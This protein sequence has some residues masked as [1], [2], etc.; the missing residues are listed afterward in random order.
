MTL[1]S[2]DLYE[3]DP[4]TAWAEDVVAGKLIAGPHIRNAA[5]RHLGDL[6]KGRDRGLVWMPEKG[7]QKIN[8]IEKYCRLNGGRFEGKPFLLHNSQKFRV[9][10]IFGWYKDDG[11]RRFNYLYDEEGKGNGKSPLLA[12]IGSVMLMA[13]GRARAEVYA[14]A[15]KKDQA[16]ILFRDAV[17]MIQQSPALASRT[18]INGV[19]P[20][21][22]IIYSSKAVGRCVFKP[23]SSDN[24]Q[25]GAR[26]FC[27]LADEIHEHKNSN[28]VEM[29]EAGAR[30][31]KANSLIAKATNSG[32][33]RK[34]FCYGEHE[35]AVKVS[36]GLA[37]DDSL[38]AFVCSLDIGDDWMNDPSCWAKPNPLLNITIME[39]DIAAAVETAR[40]I[41]S[42]AAMIARLH[43]CEWN[44]AHSV[45]MQRDTI[46]RCIDESLSD[47]EFND[48]RFVTAIDLSM[49]RDMTG[50]VNVYDDGFN[51][52]GQPCYAITAKGYLPRENIDAREHQDQAPYKVWADQGHLTLTH[53]VKVDYAQVIDDIVTDANRNHLEFIVY[54]DWMAQFF[55]DELVRAGADELPMLEHPQAYNRRKNTPLYMPDSIAIFEQL[56]MEGRLRI[57]KNPALIAAIMSVVFEHSPAGLRKPLKNKATARIDLAVAAM[58]GVGGITCNES[59]VAPIDDFIKNPIYVSA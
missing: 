36:A 10:S 53:G 22:E 50:R 16:M 41:P 11:N 52:K 51:S 5:K 33:D 45:W 15:A 29:L 32:H 25:S 46:E 18:S 43:F 7:I 28:T 37:M 44:E 13:D 4:V 39:N 30:K 57:Q 8:W 23:I 35:H 54:D 20:P 14:A 48:T 21:K 42:K 1:I 24:A 2:R 56:V 31:N 38:L 6:E 34:S 59:P 27:G 49:T 40:Q 26:V 19:N 12:A 17:A 3:I 47:A 58:M 9:G 55:R